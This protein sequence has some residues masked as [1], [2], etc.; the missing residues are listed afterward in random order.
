MASKKHRPEIAL[1][2]ICECGRKHRLLLG[3]G[4]LQVL[5]R[6]V[7]KGKQPTFPLRHQIF[8]P[9]GRTN[10]KGEPDYIELKK[11]QT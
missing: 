11:E 1:S 4:E 10:G 5:T 7:C 6:S 3:L 8:V 2:F 9:T